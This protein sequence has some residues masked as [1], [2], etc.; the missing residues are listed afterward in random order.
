MYCYSELVILA[1]FST[2]VAPS[3]L[4]I[5][6]SSPVELRSTRNKEESRP[7]N[8]E[9]LGRRSLFGNLSSL[10]SDARFLIPC[11]CSCPIVTILTAIR[12]PVADSRFTIFKATMHDIP[13][14]DFVHA[15][16]FVSNQECAVWLQGFGHTNKPPFR[17]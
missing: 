13:C 11:P 15:T 6:T 12:H 7:S 4:K 10:I 3:G 16:S 8:H 9:C 5:C 1:S 2:K 14:Y 17:E